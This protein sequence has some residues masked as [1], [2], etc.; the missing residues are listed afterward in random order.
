MVKEGK[1]DPSAPPLAKQVLYVEKD[2]A[3]LVVADMLPEAEK[4][5]GYPED[6]QQEYLRIRAKEMVKRHEKAE[7]RPVKVR[8]ILL[9]GKNEC[10]MPDW[11][12]SKQLAF[13]EFEGGNDGGGILSEKFSFDALVVN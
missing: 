5:T 8:M 12:G 4:I 2:D 3:P 11:A 7:G 9:R 10:G 1:P 6:A 13:F